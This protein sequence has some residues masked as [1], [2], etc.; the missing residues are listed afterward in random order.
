MSIQTWETWFLWFIL[1]SVIGWAYESLI[2]SIS[3]K[4]LIN[5][6]FL[7]GPYCPI[8]GSG[9]LLVILVLGKIR[10]PL[11]LFLLG[12]VLCCL[13]EYIA[14]YA[15]EKIFHARWW[16]YSKRRWNIHGRVC[17]LG[18]VVFG[19]FSVILIRELHPVMVSIT[20][21]FSEKGQH[22]VS[23]VLFLIL[24]SDGIVTITGFAGFQKKVEEISAFME[25]QKNIATEKIYGS[26]VYKSVRELRGYIK[27]KLSLQQRRMIASF[28]TLKLKGTD[29]NDMLKKIRSVLKKRREETSL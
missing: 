22:M 8:Y 27:E 21:R 1:Y 18:A 14:S 5:R 25:Q 17:L 15:M 19:L 29:H 2:C 26:E 9:A 12:A 3:N 10:N 24:L 28:P 4:K 6:G 11:W 16:D 7:N 23:G 13:L 20:D